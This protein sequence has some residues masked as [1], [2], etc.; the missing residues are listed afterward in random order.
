MRRRRSSITKAGKSFSP[1]DETYTESEIRKAV[2]RHL[3][4]KD[5]PGWLWQE[6]RP[7]HEDLWDQ[8]S[9]SEEEH[10]ALEALCRDASGRLYLHR[11]RKSRKRRREIEKEVRL[12]GLI[13]PRESKRA[14]VLSDELAR[15]AASPMCTYLS[16]VTVLEFR[17]RY[18]GGKLLTEDQAYEFLNSDA[19]RYTDWIAGGLIN[20][21]GFGPSCRIVEDRYTVNK[22]PPMHRHKIM[23]EISW[24]GLQH[25]SGTEYDAVHP[26]WQELQ[27]L[28]KT[29]EIKSIQVLPS[30]AL[31]A[32]K[33]LSSQLTDI[34]MWKEP[35]A[36]WFVLTGKTPAVL[37][38]TADL[39]GGWN[40]DHTQLR[41]VLSIQP[42]VS[43]KTVMRVYRKVQQDLLRK[44]NRHPRIQTLELFEFVAA[45]KLAGESW[46]E[47]QK[48]WDKT[49]SKRDRY[50]PKGV[51][52][53]QRDFEAI[54]RLVMRPV[55]W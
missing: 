19:L 7:L 43:A 52:N 14:K 51:R 54:Y 24:E 41:F 6:L 20:A 17:E 55:D 18:L 39:E 21:P 13:D 44:E 25:F 3:R 31:G 15:L 48:G 38:L 30:S 42:W 5:V 8:P 49:R 16:G 37:C 46:R 40:P 22:F 26:G 29:G 34:F 12:N 28:D 32:L 11:Q 45:R 35:E 9:G 33:K 36:T 27:F 50:G 1:G 23:F 4:K 53:L 10:T 2:A 47:I